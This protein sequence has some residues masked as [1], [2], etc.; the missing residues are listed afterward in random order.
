MK[1]ICVVT[2]EWASISCRGSRSSPAS[3]MLHRL[4]ST[5]A[6]NRQIKHFF[7]SS[8][9][10]VGEIKG[11]MLDVSSVLNV[12]IVLFI[13][14]AMNST[15]WVTSC[16]VDS[17]TTIIQMK[18]MKAFYW[19]NTQNRSQSRIMNCRL[20]EKKNLSSVNISVQPLSCPSVTR[21]KTHKYI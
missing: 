18:E 17:Q 11:V 5:V 3:D 7:A 12:V 20:T 8:V 21:I 13:H 1:N 6:L 16:P 10:T 15:Y 4:V 19:Q 2:L 9:A 14:S